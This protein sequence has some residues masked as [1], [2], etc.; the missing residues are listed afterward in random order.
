[1]LDADYP[2]VVGPVGVFVFDR[3]YDLAFY[4]PVF[5]SMAYIYDI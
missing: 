4:Q 1:M 3:I 2:V 5:R